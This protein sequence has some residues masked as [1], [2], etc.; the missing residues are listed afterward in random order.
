MLLYKRETDKTHTWR[1]AGPGRAPV[2][3]D[4][5]SPLGRKLTRGAF[6]LDGDRERACRNLKEEVEEELV[7]T[8]ETGA[9]GETRDTCQREDKRDLGDVTREYEGG[10]EKISIARLC[11]GNVP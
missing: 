7:D 5:T 9:E 11:T 1:S 3:T 4:E 8:T 10:V 6:I 2:T